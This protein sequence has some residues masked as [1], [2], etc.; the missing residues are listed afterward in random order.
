MVMRNMDYSAITLMGTSPEVI[1]SKENKTIF[2][3]R[4]TTSAERYCNEEQ[5]IT[6]SQKQNLRNQRDYHLRSIRSKICVICEICGK[7]KSS[8]DNLRHQRNLRAI[9]TR[10]KNS[11]KNL[12]VSY[13]NLIFAVDSEIKNKNYGKDH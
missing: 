3:I 10:S 7:K 9:M 5:N 1:L 13:K 6:F 4:A 2:L 11:P 8:E 12:V